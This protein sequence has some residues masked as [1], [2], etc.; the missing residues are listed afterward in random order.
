MSEIHLLN[1]TGLELPKAAATHILSVGE[2]DRFAGFHSE[3]RRRE[4][5]IGRFFLKATLTGFIPTRVKEFRRISPKTEVAG[6]PSLPGINFNLSHSG[7]VFILSIGKDAV[8]VDIEPVQYFDDETA[9]FC[10]SQQQ[11]E[12]IACSHHPERLATLLWC[13]REAQGKLMGT[14]LADAEGACVQTHRRGGFVTVNET[15]YAWAL[16]SSAILSRNPWNENRSRI[17]SLLQYFT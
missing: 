4:F 14:G 15:P 7:E 10:F 8:G 12:K 13:L 17:H 11:R 5:L 6:K 3:R 1:A 16:A 2:Q 9:S